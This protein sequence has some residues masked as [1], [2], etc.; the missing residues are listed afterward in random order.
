MHFFQ[1]E[2][3]CITAVQSFVIGTPECSETLEN[4]DMERR[5]NMMRRDSAALASL[6]SLLRMR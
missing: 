6:S 5:R 3:E 2:Q 4:E 1:R